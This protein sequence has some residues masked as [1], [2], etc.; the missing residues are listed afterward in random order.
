MAFVYN[1]YIIFSDKK[2]KENLVIESTQWNLDRTRS[3]IIS[4]NFPCIQGMMM[5]FHISPF[6]L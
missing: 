5:D 1:F 4:T 2:H 6:S 3:R